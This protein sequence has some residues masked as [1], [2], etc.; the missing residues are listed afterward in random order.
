VT[1]AHIPDISSPTGFLDILYLGVFLILSPAL[2]GRFYATSKPRATLAEEFS[3]AKDHFHHLLHV[4]SERFIIVLEGKA[5]AHSYVVERMLAEFAA[6]VVV[7]AKALSGSLDD[8]ADGITSNSV[9]EHMAG[10]LQESYGG[11]VPYFLQCVERNHKFFIWTGPALQIHQHF[12][13]LGSVMPLLTVGAL[14]D[15]PSHQIYPLT[16]TTD[17]PS[18]IP[19]DVSVPPSEKRRSPEDNLDRPATKPKKRRR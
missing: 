17:P 12:D 1:G 10:I 16:T 15:L 13:S 4:F 19:V 14:L 6:A 18:D 2:D 5:V 8:G 9:R 3:H 7:F 11:V